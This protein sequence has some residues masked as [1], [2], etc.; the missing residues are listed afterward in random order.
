MIF[1]IKCPVK[2]KMITTP[3]SH[4]TQNINSTWIVNLNLKEKN[5]T[6]EF[7]E[8]NV[9]LHDIGA[10]QR[11]LKQDVK[12]LNI[13]ELVDKMQHIKIKNL[14]FLKGTVLGVK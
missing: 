12:S 3:V 7:L 11:F 1:S 14:R 13:L 2:W 10:R 9:Y 8:D 6:I 5:R 4:Y